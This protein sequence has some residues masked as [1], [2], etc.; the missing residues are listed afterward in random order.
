[1]N[2]TITFATLHQFLTR[3]GFEKTVVPGSHVAYEHPA[4]GSVFMVR[5]HQPGDAVPWATQTSV[6]KQLSER[7]L[8]EPEEFDAL[9]RSKSA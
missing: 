1:M 4:S 9:F 6:R 8:I 5:P 3:L 7:G 2:E